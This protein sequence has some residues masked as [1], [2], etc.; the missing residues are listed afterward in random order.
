MSTELLGLALLMALVTYPSRAIPI[1]AGGAERLAPGI[2]AYLR[3]VAPAVLAALAA[4]G[5]AVTGDG[6]TG[7]SLH[8]G[9]EWLSVGVTVAAV[10]WRRS[11]VGGLLAG[12]VLAAL[13]RG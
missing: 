3:L 9:V 8:V 1:L 6:G 5:V 2:R 4:T 12:I 7:W 10:A 13:L 11:L